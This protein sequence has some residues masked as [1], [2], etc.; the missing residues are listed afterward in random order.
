[1]SLQLLLPTQRS[2]ATSTGNKNNNIGSIAFYERQS[3]ITDGC[4]HKT[5]MPV[6]IMCMS[7]YKIIEKDKQ[8]ALLCLLGAFLILCFC[9][10]GDREERI[11]KEE[12][13]CWFS[14]FC[15]WLPLHVPL[16]LCSLLFLLFA[17]P[18][19]HGPTLLDVPRWTNTKGQSQRKQT[20]FVQTL[21]PFIQ[22]SLDVSTPGQK[23]GCLLRILEDGTLRSGIA[24][25]T[26]TMSEKE[27]ARQETQDWD[28][29]CW[30]SRCK[31]EGMNEGNEK[32]TQ[33]AFLSSFSF[34]HLVRD[35][36]CFQSGYCMSIA[37][38]NSVN[39]GVQA[40]RRVENKIWR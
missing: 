29:M 28:A 24:R 25:R 17:A 36:N 5:C 9:A 39:G 7:L 16:F 34:Q 33:E 18:P 35:Y 1:M 26:V 32:D 3:N 31:E 27:K 14:L 40:G 23:E 4:Q 10:W 19:P 6:Y 21:T 11:E 13:P 38:C 30:L 8:S 20:K 15:V 22:S 37:I 12:A 2:H